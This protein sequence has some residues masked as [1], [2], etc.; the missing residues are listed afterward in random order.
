[1]GTFPGRIARG[2]GLINYEVRLIKKVQVIELKDKKVVLA[3]SYGFA[4]VENRVAADSGTVYQIGSVTKMF[5]GYV[6]ASLVEEGAIS[7]TLNE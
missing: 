6:L 3:K 2:I 5:T 7:G 4:D 1:M